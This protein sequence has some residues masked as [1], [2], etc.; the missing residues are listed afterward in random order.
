MHPWDLRPEA[1]MALQTKLARRV[2]QKSRWK[3][4]DIT[5]VAGADTGYR[6]GIAHAAVVVVNLKDLKTV[7]KAVAARAV[8]YPYIPGLFSF[9]EG[10]VMLEALE[11]LKKP[12]DILMIEGQGIAH[13][14]R[15]GIASH[16]G[17]L[18]GISTIGCAKTRLVGDYTVPQPIR[19]ST[20]ILKDGEE[21][22]GAAVR[23][24]TG[25]KP[26]YV[27]IGHLIDLADSIR[28]V[29]KSC[30]GYRLPEPLRIADHLSRKQR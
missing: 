12:P 19:G 4:E 25:V 29:L 23:T 20:T 6:D 11:K 30:C 26:V 21:T 9:R 10:P 2:I 22:I 24:R 7:E 17:V 28:L 8:T 16:I 13:P 1:A 27:S 18:L 5:T 14:R 3:S 15:F